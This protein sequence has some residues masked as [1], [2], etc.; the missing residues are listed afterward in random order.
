MRDYPQ[1]DPNDVKSWLTKVFGEDIIFDTKTAAASRGGNENK[2][3]VLGAWTL[4]YTGELLL[5]VDLPPGQ[6]QLLA[7]S[8]RSR[9]ENAMHAALVPAYYNK[10]IS[11]RKKAVRKSGWPLPE[12]VIRGGLNIDPALLKDLAGRM[13]EPADYTRAFAGEVQATE[14]EWIERKEK[15][16]SRCA[17]AFMGR[18]QGEDVNWRFRYG[19]RVDSGSGMELAFLLPEIWPPVFLDND[20]EGNGWAKAHGWEGHWAKRSRELGLDGAFRYSNFH[21]GTH[22]PIEEQKLVLHA[23]SDM[24]MGNKIDVLFDPANLPNAQLYFNEVLGTTLTKMW[25]NDY[26]PDFS[27]ELQRAWDAVKGEGEAAALEYNEIHASLE[28]KEKYAQWRDVVPK[29]IEAYPTTGAFVKA[30]HNPVPQGQEE[31]YETLR[32]WSGNTFPSLT[33]VITDGKFAPIPPHTSPE[34]SM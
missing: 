20:A 8:L 11:V 34:P 33:K 17:V 23:R 19:N 10:P 30:L 26:H 4:Y 14:A 21:Y 12:D 1:Y 25:L 7:E 28:K 13:K 32:N 9:L 3:N 31:V 5:Q 15:L 22:A 29:L 24:D 27:S 18:E 16:L 6:N 2:D